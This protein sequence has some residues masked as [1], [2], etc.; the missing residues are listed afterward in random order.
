M[1]RSERRILRL[2]R[3]RA[4]RFVKCVPL[5]PL[6]VAA[7]TFSDPQH[8]ISGEWDW[9]WVEINTHRRLRPGMFVLQV[10]GKS[11]EPAVPDGSYCLFSGPVTGTRQGRTVIAQLLDNNDPETGERYTIK[12]YQSEKAASE[13]GGWRHIKIILKPNNPDFQPIELTCEDEGS[14][15]V[16]AELLE[17]IG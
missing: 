13:D 3:P 11:M 6:K 4:K 16:V 17:V 7:G 10:Q 5:V 2:V 14:V 8:L 9:D 12:R 1:V 15:A